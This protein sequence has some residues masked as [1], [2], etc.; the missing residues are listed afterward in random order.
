MEAGNSQW[1]WQPLEGER[2]G[3]GRAR[4]LLL[5]GFRAPSGKPC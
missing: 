3:D 4:G 5:S 2:C 1:G